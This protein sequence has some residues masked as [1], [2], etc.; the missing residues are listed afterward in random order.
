MIVTDSGG[1]RE[2]VL[3]GETGRVVSADDE[4]AVLTAMQ[5]LV[6]DRACAKITGE[7]AM[8]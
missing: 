8:Q 2:D 5:Q 7:R 6:L 1:P 4:E 3:P